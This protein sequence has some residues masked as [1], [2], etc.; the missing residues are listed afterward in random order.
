MVQK[1]YS[2][3][4]YEKAKLEGLDLD[5]WKDYETYFQLGENDEG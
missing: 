1:P 3:E 2:A 4:D 5:N